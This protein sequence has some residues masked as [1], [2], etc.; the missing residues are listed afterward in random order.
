M[1]G[2][3]EKRFESFLR[4]FWLGLLSGK[5]IED[6]LSILLERVFQI[7]YLSNRINLFIT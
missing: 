2:L 6:Q 4:I 7:S 5:I 1:E 3:K